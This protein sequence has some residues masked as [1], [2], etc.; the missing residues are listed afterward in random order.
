MEF[1]G[2]LSQDP[3]MLRLFELIKRVAQFDSTVLIQGE[4]GTG[5]ELVAA[6]IHQFSSRADKP[7]VPVNCG[8]LPETLLESELF[9]HERGAFTGAD[10][11]RKGIFEQAN[12]GTLFLD[13]IGDTSPSLQ[14]KL[15][16]VLQHKQVRPVGGTSDVT[17]DVRIVSATNSD[18]TAAVDGKRFREDLF[19]RLNA[20]TV[21]LPPLRDRI[22]D[23]PM[24]ARH[25]LKQAAARMG[26]GNEINTD[27]EVIHKLLRYSWPGNI[28]ELEHMMEAAAFSCCVNAGPPE[29]QRHAITL[30]DLPMLTERVAT[31]PRRTRLTDT[32]FYLAREQWERE[33]IESLLKRCEFNFS[34]ASRLGQISRKSLLIKA[35]RY[36]L[37]SRDQPGLTEEAVTADIGAS[38]EDGV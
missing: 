29:A 33:Y 18:L 20:V 1:C 38:N 19:Y 21:Q 4:S 23:V 2:M 8:A 36:G 16:R 10:R 31:H 22:D 24:L 26:M 6:A 28:R 15:L 7:F 13:E 14:V 37:V 25:F 9:G 12:G 35:R 30:T 32:P 27:Q 17:V 11:A 3:G 5:K 34:A